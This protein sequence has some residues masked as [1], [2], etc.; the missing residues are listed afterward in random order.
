MEIPS[1]DSFFAFWL[2]A[3]CRVLPPQRRKKLLITY[4]KFYANYV[5]E[6]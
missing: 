5:K 3:T 1:V 2:W 6:F 4:L